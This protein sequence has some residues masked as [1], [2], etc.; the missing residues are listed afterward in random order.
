MNLAFKAKITPLM[1]FPPM[2]YDEKGR[3]WGFD[4]FD[5]IWAGVLAKKIIDH[6]NM[7]A[8]SGSPYVEHRQKSSVLTN[9]KK[10][11]SGIKVNEDFFQSVK[12]V[13]LKS[14]SI[15][16]CYEELAKKIRLP[17]KQYFNKLKQ[18]MKIWANI[19]K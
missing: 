17:N 3:L 4:R 11:K 19:T 13:E 12:K 2:G 5:D 8:L 9:L 6:L 16:G 7:V 15:N 10:E 18:A 14:R 1:Y